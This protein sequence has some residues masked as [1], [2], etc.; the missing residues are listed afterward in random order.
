M[1]KAFV[2][3]FIVVVLAITLTYVYPFFSELLFNLD[4]S[5]IP[6]SDAVL[7]YRFFLFLIPLV[8]PASWCILGSIQ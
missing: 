2:I 6:A 1:T 3:A 4:L 8:I 5:Q 7:V